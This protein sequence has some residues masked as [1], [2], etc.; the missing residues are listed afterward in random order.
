M[1]AIFDIETAPLAEDKIRQFMP[2]FEAPSN[3]KDPE[4]IKAYREEK[5]KEW[6]QRGALDAITGRVL[7]IG[8]IAPNGN[9]NALEGDEPKILAEFWD[10]VTGWLDHGVDIVGFNSHRF[11]LPFLVRRSLINSVAIPQR[12]RVSQGRYWNDHFIDLMAVWS[13]GN[14][15]QTI[16]LDNLS[17]TLGVGQKNG[18]GKDFAE[19]YVMDRA[20]AMGYLE[21]DLRLTAKCAERMGV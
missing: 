7:V 12:L 2:D 19:L 4:K 20:A 1:K 14:R 16:S 21:N 17:R 18:D 8:M 13:C 10:I 3:Y 9:L 6:L 15:D 5:A 11:D